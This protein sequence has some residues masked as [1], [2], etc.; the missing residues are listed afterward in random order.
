LGGNLQPQNPQYSNQWT[1][2]R[3]GDGFYHRLYVPWFYI[4][5]GL[6]D[7]EQDGHKEK[8][9]HGLMDTKRDFLSLPMRNM[10]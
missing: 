9:S 3:A 1:T 7:K 5:Q 10:G 8:N 2:D 4:K 6:E